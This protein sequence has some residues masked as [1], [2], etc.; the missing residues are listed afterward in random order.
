[1]PT[2]IRRRRDTPRVLDEVRDLLERQTDFLT[3]QET[4]GEFLVQVPAY[5]GALRREPRIAIHMED[6]RLEA[7]DLLSLHE[8]H[9]TEE[10]ADLVQLRE[11]LVGAAPETDD[12]AQP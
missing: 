8:V 1:M 4:E 2:Y 10:I 12:A 7:S 11:E 9:D 3:R 5:L 6:L